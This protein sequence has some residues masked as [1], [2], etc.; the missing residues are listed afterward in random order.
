MLNIRLTGSAVLVIAAL[1]AAAWYW[2]PSPA[3]QPKAPGETTINVPPGVPS[4]IRTNGGQLVVAILKV[5]ERFTKEDPRIILGMSMGTTKSIVQAD[6]TY[7][8]HIEM[9]KRWPINIA[10][11]T[12]TVRAPA[13]VPSLP[14][15]FDSASV[16]KYTESGWARF[17]KDENLA[18]LERSITQQIQTRASSP[19]YEQIKRD[20]ARQA[21]QMFV[22]T[23]LLS[24]R[25]WGETPE[26]R[27]VV[28]F[29]GETL[30]SQQVSNPR[31]GAQ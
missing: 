19:Q 29:P 2:F 7:R 17:N 30:E 1:G 31:Q 14:A 13:L 11:K 28:L 6:V 18:A 26:Y 16:R 3:Q 5:T 10:E 15:A 21:L 24:Q 25:K 20:A 12:A 8:Y 9:E 23:W 27:I 4:E 22:K